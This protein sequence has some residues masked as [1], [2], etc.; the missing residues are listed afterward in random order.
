MKIRHRTILFGV[1]RKPFASL[2]L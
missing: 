1:Q 2:R